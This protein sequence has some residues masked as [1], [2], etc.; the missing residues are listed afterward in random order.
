MQPALT[1]PLGGL[2]VLS[3][4]MSWAWARQRR[5]GNAGIVDLIWSASLGVLAAAYAVGTDG[6]LPRR[7]LVG[8]LAGAWSARLTLHL[9]Q[10][11]MGEP[12]DG[13][14]TA[15]REELGD[16]FDRW[17]HWFFQAQA[18]LS[19][20]LSLTFLT[21]CLAPA[22]GW[23]VWDALAVFL[24]LVSIGGESLAD[25]QLRAW[26]ADPDNAGKT[27]RRG[28]WASSRHPNYFFEWLHWLVYPILGIGLPLGWA[29]WFTPAL[30]LFLVLKVTGIP[31]TEEQSLRSRGADYRA[32]QRTTNAFFP[33]PRKSEPLHLL[34]NS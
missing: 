18:V 12:E 28:L 6:W 31:P 5:T 14:Y 32:Y 10:R 3:L 16:R 8:V 22:E 11:V 13:R 27:C 33:G 4:A 15:L 1:L 9:Y 7:V 2:I 26:R 29:L 23:R 30:M 25:R 20:L 34:E 21:L 24:W 19:V 17:I